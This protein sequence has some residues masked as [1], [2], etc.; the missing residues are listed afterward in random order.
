MPTYDYLCEAGHT[1]ATEQ[2]IKD[3]PLTACPEHAWG[4]E[5]TGDPCGHPVKRLISDTSFHLRGPGWAK[6]GYSSA[7]EKKGK[8]KK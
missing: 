4:C 2:N 3:E 1:F 5:L 7:G 6:D 8:E